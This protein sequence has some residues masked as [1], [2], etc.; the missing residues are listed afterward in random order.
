MTES[1]KT[2]IY[3]LSLKTR[4]GAAGHQRET[5]PV[6][7]SSQSYRDPELN[8]TG[9]RLPF[10]KATQNLIKVGV[11]LPFYKSRAE[12]PVETELVGRHQDLTR[13]EL[14]SSLTRHQ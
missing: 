8:K 1:D 9:A 3:F 6:E 11:T 14:S 12:L 10:Y 5:R 4:S 7:I 13:P 2:G